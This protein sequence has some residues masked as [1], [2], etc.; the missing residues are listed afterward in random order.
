MNKVH[1]IFSVKFRF[2]ENPEAEARSFMEVILDIDKL[3]VASR[4]LKA[5]AEWAQSKNAE[6]LKK[7]AADDC[8]FMSIDHASS[9]GCSDLPPDPRRDDGYVTTSVIMPDGNLHETQKK[10]DGTLETFEEVAERE[11]AAAVIRRAAQGLE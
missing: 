10:P 3:H 4:A 9:S 6:T 1:P 11:L 7:Y 8:M 5:L 2:A